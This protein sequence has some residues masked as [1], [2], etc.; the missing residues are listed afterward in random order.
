MKTIV[1][2][3]VAVLL[4]GLLVS[5]CAPSL[6]GSAYSRS[7][8]RET[9]QVQFGIVEGVRN[10]LIEGTKSGVGTVSGAALGGLAGSTVG[11]GRGKAAA[12]IGGAVL[13]GL[14]GAA[15]EEGVTRRRGLEITVR[16]D[17]GRFIAVTQEADEIFNPGE[18]V[19]ILTGYDGTTRV[20]R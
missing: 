4:L 10:V 13:G 11:G 5:G 9:Q 8:A 2:P 7:Q 18:R 20:T 3:I 6:S 14:A 16:L 19:R 17:N 15:T 12:T 1:T